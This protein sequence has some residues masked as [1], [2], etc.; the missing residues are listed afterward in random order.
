MNSHRT[1]SQIAAIVLAI[2]V[3]L[4][5]LTTSGYFFLT[6]APVQVAGEAYQLA[7]KIAEDIDRVFHFRPT[8]TL[9]GT[10]FVESS[11][12][13]AELSTVEKRFESSYDWKSTW[14]GSEKIIHLEGIFLAKAGYDLTKPFAMD[15]ANDSKTI[16]LTL[17]PA[18]LNSVEPVDI[19]KFSVEHGYVN[20]VSEEEKQNALNAFLAKTK[21]DIL[22]TG[23]LADAD[24]ALVKQ[25]T[26]IIQR[27]APAPVTI[28]REPLR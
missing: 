6:K 18:K 28:Q 14:M 16:K 9:G 1:P 12:S 24:A 26:E 13:I 19:K 22:A 4:A 5:V 2:V 8:V 3:V 23:I 27:N 20:W 7:K 17:P 15:V 21:E 25:I 11:R 10:M